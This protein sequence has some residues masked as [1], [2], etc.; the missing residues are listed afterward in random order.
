MTFEIPAF[1]AVDVDENSEG[2][3]GFGSTTNVASSVVYSILSHEP[4]EYQVS[5]LSIARDPD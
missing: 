1:K 3:A 2:A 5:S 4:E